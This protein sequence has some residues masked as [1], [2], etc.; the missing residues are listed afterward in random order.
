MGLDGNEKHGANFGYNIHNR[1]L[2]EALGR[3]EQ[4]EF[5][6]ILNDADIVV[7]VVYPS[8][9]RPIPNKINLAFIQ[10]E[11]DDVM[12]PAVWSSVINKASALVTSSKQSQKIE[13]RYFSGPVFLCPLGV[14]ADKFPYIERKKPALNEPFVYLWANN[15]TDSKGLPYMLELWDTWFDS[16]NAPPNAVLY[17][18][19][20]GVAD[21]IED[22]SLVKT[23]RIIFDTRLVPS[24]ELRDIYQGAHAFLNT[25]HGDGF[26]LTQFEALST[27]LPSVWTHWSAFP[28]YL[29]ASMGFP[30]TNYDLKPFVNPSDPSKIIGH[31]AYADPTQFIYAIWR[32]YS[33]YDYALS[34]GRAAAERMR[35]QYTWENAAKRF[36]EI[37]QQVL[38]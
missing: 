12:E 15:F 16:G 18:R 7:H 29:D 37:C 8:G 35:T 33:R 4:V 9:F 30:I 19:G 36:Y 34:L 13:K 25:S 17:V 23:R 24:E 1:K 28:D 2:K 11:L 10:T 26:G 14:D 6:E 32:I 31:G 22:T 20:S 3:L 38:K 5:T 21:G 27:G